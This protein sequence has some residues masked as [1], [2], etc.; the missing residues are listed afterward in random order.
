MHYRAK[1]R[2]YIFLCGL[3]WNWRCAI[4]GIWHRFYDDC[5]NSA[6]EYNLDMARFSFCLCVVRF[7]RLRRAASDCRYALLSL[8]GGCERIYFRCYG[9]TRLGQTKTLCRIFWNRF[10]RFWKRYIHHIYDKCEFHNRM[11]L[12]G[13]G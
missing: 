1:S 7:E 9:L 2:R 4:A 5:Y 11:A 13:S 10:C 8:W 12:A 3:F 6:I